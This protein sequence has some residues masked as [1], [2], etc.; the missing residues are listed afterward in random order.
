MHVDKRTT[1]VI[2]SILHIDHGANDEPWPLVIE[3]FHGDTNEI[4]L[5]P[6]DMLFYES[7]KCRHGRPKK[8]RGEFYSSL[9]LHYKPHP[10]N[11]W[12]IDEQ[13]MDIHYRIPSSDVWLKSAGIKEDFDVQEMSLISLC[14]KEPSCHHEWCRLKDSVKWYG[15]GPDYGK[16]L[17]G[18]GRLTDLRRI[19]SEES[20]DKI[21]DEL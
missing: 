19:P 4:F 7:S 6:G 9:F 14:M 5:E 8:F 13:T 16:V 11:N 10:R 2:S 21:E 18:K 1:H 17:T 3:D 15:P 20:F 12:N